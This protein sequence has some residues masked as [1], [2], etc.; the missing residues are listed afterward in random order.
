MKLNV[1][2]IFGGR[3]VEHEMSIISAVQA[4]NNIDSDKYDNCLLQTDDLLYRLTQV[5]KDKKAVILYSSD[6]GQSFGEQGVYMH[7]GALSVIQ[8]RHV[9]SFLWYSDA[10]A[11]AHPEMIQTVKSNA[12]RLLSHDDIYSSVLSLSGIECSVPGLENNDF[13]KA[14]N[15]PV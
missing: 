6:H 13:T 9:F 11:Q 14:L 8:Q 15:R 7:G 12:M 5:L 1:G 3:S 10:Y 2:V 4:M